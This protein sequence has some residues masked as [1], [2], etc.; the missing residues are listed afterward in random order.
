MRKFIVTALTGTSSLMIATSA[1]AQTSTNAPTA[2][3]AG[4]SL[5]ND[6]IVTARRREE[7][8][9]DVPQTVDVVTGAALEELN[10]TRFEDVTTVVP[11]LQ[12]SQQG[13]V[14]FRTTLR[15]VGVDTIGG[16]APNVEYYINDAN[17]SPFAL[18][19]SMYDIG[20]IEV[21]RGPQ[22]TLRGK[23]S[24]SGSI[25]VTTRRADLQ[26]FGGTLQGSATG[27]G[28][29]NVQGGIGIPIIPG[30]AALRVAGV[31]D[32]NDANEVRPITPAT[33]PFSNTS[34]A[35]ASLRVE[36]SD[37]LDANVTYQYLRRETEFYAQVES[38]GV[39]QPTT[40]PQFGG[41]TFIRGRDRRSV[42]DTPGR[43]D[44]RQ[45]L[46]TANANLR[47]AG[48]Q[49]SYVGS[50]F[51]LK[52]NTAQ[53]QDNA[54]I[55]P[56]DD[57]RQTVATDASQWTHEVRL[58]SDERLF[59]FLDYTAGAFFL[60][61]SGHNDIGQPRL[62]GANFGQPILF[63]IFMLPL[64]NEGWRKE[65][66][67]FGNL[68]AHIGEGTELSGGLRRIRITD[69]TTT[70][71][72]IPGFGAIPIQASNPRK[73]H[74]TIYN[75]SIKHEFSDDLMVYAN[76]G[77]S[78]RTNAPAI[79]IGRP[80]TQGL[81]Q[82]LNIDP[83]KSTSYEVGFKASMMDRKISI[84]AAAFHQKFKNF[85]F[86]D[87]QITNFIDLVNPAGSQTDP[88][89]WRI[90]GF[91]FLA[92]LPVTVKG[93]ELQ[94]TYKPSRNFYLDAQLAYADGKIKN[95]TIAC[96]D[97]DGDGVPDAAIPTPQQ[98]FDVSGGNAVATCTVNQ[99]VSTQPDWSL[100]LQ[101]EYSHP[102]SPVTA[103][104]IRGNFTYNPSN[105][106]NP[107]NRFDRVKAYG[108]LNLY[109]GLRSEDGAWELAL[110]AKN[111]TNT[112]R[113][114]SR[115][116]VPLSTSVSLPP[117]LGGASLN[118]PSN[119]VGVSSTIPREFGLSL[120][121]AFGSR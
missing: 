16:A 74:A 25:T 50:Y 78:F 56:D 99:R 6:I 62:T 100:N 69:D 28:A 38:I 46:V 45:H 70:T 106:N 112:Y 26:E 95:G 5:G 90:G 118:F 55:F 64:I 81:S 59:G 68:V 98:I 75:A 96:N 49:L 21:L 40:T 4:P 61:T 84:S 8:L 60:K 103:A 117:Q 83:E 29:I 115:S 51:D 116:D 63:N 18:F 1:L 17:V 9:Q 7:S 72:I 19:Q 88:T 42:T 110:F 54:N 22:G 27:N 33:K 82:F 35:R 24:P 77:T 58:S 89:N 114:L 94:V 91:P 71:A 15:G 37:M 11:G 119:Y 87:T 65:R 85:L 10:I 57:I 76:T 48:Q 66:S 101:S 2:Q 3:E 111:I 53:P 34:S 102:I 47:L 93:V 121:F 44:E 73:F 79:G 80:L 92:N 105:P 12:L 36:P 30:I 67:F 107:N 23:A 31:V 52:Q 104:F 43:V 97:V 32:Q 14:G 39:S 113:M 20:Q 86:K 41:T 108:L 13:G 109:A 120:R